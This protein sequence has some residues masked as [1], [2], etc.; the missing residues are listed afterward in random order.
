MA[1][2][3]SKFTGQEIDARLTQGTYDDAVKAGFK[4]TKEEFYALLGQLQETTDSAT[5]SQPAESDKLETFN[6]NIVDAINELHQELQSEPDFATVAISGDYNDLTNTPNLTVYQT[7][8]DE[9]LQTTDKTVTGAINELQKAL[10]LENVTKVNVEVGEESTYINF[11]GNKR[12]NSAYILSTPIALKAGQVLYGK[13]YSNRYI[14]V[15]SESIGE[16][17]KYNIIKSGMELGDGIKM[18]CYI[19]TKDIEVILTKSKT[20]TPELYIADIVLASGL[21]RKGGQDVGFEDLKYNKL[22]RTPNQDDEKVDAYEEG[23]LDCYID[24]E[25]Y[26]NAAIH[27]MRLWCY[28]ATFYISVSIGDLNDIIFTKSFADINNY[29]PVDIIVNEKKIGYVVFSDKQKFLDNKSENG[30][31]L[32]KSWTNRPHEYIWIYN[33]FLKDVVKNLLNYRILIFL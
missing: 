23:L 32:N 5:I 27:D 29:E 6:K 22:V 10:G 18:L 4:G 28:G 7:I 1:F 12:T 33:A 13:T 26:P 21:L 14:T 17:D 30:P 19:P 31:N 20:I 8:T 2:Y 15:L 25:L 9:S 3:K 11:Y 16:N 24:T